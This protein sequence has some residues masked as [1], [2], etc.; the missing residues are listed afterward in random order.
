VPTDVDPRAPGA[1]AYLDRL[2]EALLDR[3]QAGGEAYLSNAVVG[4]TFLLRACVVNFRTTL[5][6]IEALAT[7]VVRLG[8][9]LD[10]ELRP[11][12]V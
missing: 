4:G 12:A 6:D 3:L 7:L 5:A 9:E 10:A 2:N 1:P 11:E 8:R